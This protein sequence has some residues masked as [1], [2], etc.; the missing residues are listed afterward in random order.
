MGSGG[1]KTAHMPA[2]TSMAS[3]SSGAGVSRETATPWPR[4]AV[5]GDSVAEGLCEPVDGYPHVQWADRI[6]AEL[7]AVRPE[8]AYLI[9]R[10]R[11]LRGLR[12]H[13]VR[14]NQLALALEFRPDLALVVRGGNDAFGPAY[15][16][17]CTRQRPA[18]T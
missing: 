6:A 18:P 9:L 10:L 17:A 13:E 7:R 2:G 14:P 11:G 5:P 1:A 12:A 3:R 15:D 16:A 8:L 4:F